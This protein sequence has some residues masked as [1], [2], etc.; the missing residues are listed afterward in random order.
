MNA[1]SQKVRIEG[2]KKGAMTISAIK[3]I[4]HASSLGLSGSKR[5]IDDV[6]GGKI[7]RV[8][9]VSTCSAEELAAKLRGHGFVVSVVEDE[10]KA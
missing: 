2:W 1:T 9:P 4:Q 7:V 6:L 8:A 5:T 10:E 3:E